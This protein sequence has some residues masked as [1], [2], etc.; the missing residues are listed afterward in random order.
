[1]WTRPVHAHH[2]TTKKIQTQ[3]S[4]SRIDRKSTYSY[5]P[6][7]SSTVRTSQRPHARVL[8]KRRRR[9]RPPFPAM[10]G[11]AIATPAKPITNQHWAQVAYW[12]RAI[13]LFYEETGL[14]CLTDGQHRS[15]VVEDEASDAFRELRT[16]P[17]QERDT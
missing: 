9:V 15:F 16:R 8:K 7:G 12:F 6:S 17:S 5:H 13:T 14:N 4:K 2:P 1:M 3:S 10:P 11:D